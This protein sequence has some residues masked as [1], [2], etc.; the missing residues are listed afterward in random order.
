MT[1]TKTIQNNQQL[2]TRT[3]RQ[4]RSQCLIRYIFEIHLTS[5]TTRFKG[6]INKKLVHRYFCVMIILWL[7]DHYAIH[8]WNLTFSTIF[9]NLKCFFDVIGW[10]MSTSL[11]DVKHRIRWTAWMQL[12]YLDFFYA[13]RT[14]K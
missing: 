8:L 10:I 11:S 6:K 9:N 4:F 7:M 14:I 3:S 13:I 1:F 2:D 12:D 5:Q